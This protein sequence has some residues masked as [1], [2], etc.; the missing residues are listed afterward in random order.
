MHR[1][2]AV[3]LICAVAPPAE[4][5]CA[6][7]GLSPSVLTPAKDGLYANGFV[8]AAINTESGRLDP[9]D[10]ANQPGWRIRTG[11][12]I[13]NPTRVTLAPGLVLYQLSGGPTVELLDDKQKVVGKIHVTKDKRAMAFA[14]PKVKRITHDAR[15]GRK[16]SMDVIAELDGPLPADVL[17][18]VIV[19]AKG[20]AMSWGR[21]EVGKSTVNVHEER[22]CQAMPNG[23]VAPKPGDKVTLFFVGEGGQKSASSSPIV[24]VAARP[25]TPVDRD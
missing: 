2:L 11:S 7:W 6:M 23:T 20:K 10:A 16:P 5:K 1:A 3:A 13:E 12:V 9:G 8:V 25:G 4:A 22:R 19:D 15:Q 21:A 24:I 14:A 18:V 17:A